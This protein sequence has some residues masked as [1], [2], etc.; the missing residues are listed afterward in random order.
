MTS[1]PGTVNINDEIRSALFGAEAN[2]GHEAKVVGQKGVR[3]IV[4]GDE[5]YGLITD[6][7]ESKALVSV[8]PISNDKG[9]R[10]APADTAVLRVQD[11][12][13]RYVKFVKD[14]VRIG[15]IIK[16]RVIA[17]MNGIDL[18]TKGSQ[19]YGVIKAFCSR[20][21]VHMTLNNNKLTCRK[22][23]RP[24]TRK[25]SSYYLNDGE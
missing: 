19:E 6:V 13:E 7:M 5:V 20:C 9:H 12:A 24:E 21:R 22:C 18:T 10:F 11:I 17:T 1:G 16:A 8:V 15:D 2:N 3:P 25:L 23:G 14:E 4:P